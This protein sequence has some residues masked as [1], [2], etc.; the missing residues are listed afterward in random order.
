MKNKL[1]IYSKTILLFAFTIQVLLSNAQEKSLEWWNPESSP[2]AVIEGK[3]WSGDEIS[4]YGR[5]PER[6]KS[7]VREAVWNLSQN[8]SGLSIRFRSN[9]ERIVVRYKV[10]GNLAM[11]HMPA[12]GVSGVDMFAKDSEG[13]FSWCH[14]KY[15]FGD[16]ITYDFAS[17]D[18]KEK[19]HNQGREY[20]LFLP[21][22]NSVTWLE[23]G[24]N[25]GTN[26]E[27]LPLRHEKPLVV[28]G[29]SIAQGGCASR[30]GMAW[31]VIL[32]RNL[33]RPLINLAFSGNGRLEE[34]V[35]DLISEIDA[36]MFIIDC[37]PNMGRFSL[38][39]TYNR[40]IAS[41]SA[42][43][44]KH[45]DMPILLAEHAGYSDGVLNSKRFE[46][47]TS[48]NKTQQ[49]AYAD[50]IK[51]GVKHLFYLSEAEM[52]LGLDSFVDGTHPTDLGMMQYAIAYEKC[53][54]EIL[55]EPSGNIS[56]TQPVTQWREPGNYD[57][58]KRHQDILN[59]NRQNPPEICFFG[60]SIVHYWAGEP[61]ASISRGSESWNKLFAGHKVRNFGFGWDRV[62]NVLWRINHDELDGFE[63]KQ[64]LLMLGTNN[65]HLNSDEEI[66]TGLNL[67]IKTIR[68]RQTHA[69]IL[70]IGILPR[71]DYEERIRNLNYS[72][73]QTA[74]M[75]EVGYTNIGDA[76][77][78]PDGKI[79]E[80]LFTDGLHPNAAG[81]DKLSK[82]IKPNL[83]Q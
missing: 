28:Y 2:V 17:I 19:Y 45:P 36:K 1:K 54:R 76:L 53:I 37:L 20:R 38:D 4:T 23:I 51:Q 41:V 70:V 42:L 48:L 25:E 11:P 56:T 15:S 27:V 46:T 31:T 26:F 12:T 59:L 58:E 32:A 5:L 40:I 75:N 29:T 71:R 50:L 13:A 6:A 63:A 74:G 64:I 79:N 24:I 16:T 34:E 52:G 7:D 72:L 47:Y 9:S 8:S 80:S 83:I 43:R 22:Y 78:Q 77:L 10:S 3:G 66:I 69:K 49:K 57:W 39:E 55:D 61:K 44:T 30:P 62:E 68:E 67:L 18:V 73:A 65:L 21:L 35:V 14:G 81:Y 82:E 33:D 60:N